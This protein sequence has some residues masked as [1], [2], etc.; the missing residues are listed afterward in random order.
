MKNT[1]PIRRELF[2]LD[3]YVTA[4]AG[5]KKRA[6]S[7]EAMAIALD[8]EKMDRYGP[9]EEAGLIFLRD[10]PTSNAEENE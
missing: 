10:H 3:D 1:S 4:I 7:H 5:L 2:T 8:Q 9:D 6:A